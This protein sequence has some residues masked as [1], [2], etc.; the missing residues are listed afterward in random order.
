[1]QQYSRVVSIERNRY[2]LRGTNIFKKQLVRTNTKYHCI[3]VTLWN[4]CKK[5]LKTCTSLNKLK[6]MFKDNILNGYMM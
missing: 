2:S 4:K 5:E 1:M 3:I 6:L